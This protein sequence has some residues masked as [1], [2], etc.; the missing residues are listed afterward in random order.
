MDDD[1]RRD[2]MD[3]VPGDNIE[4]WKQMKGRM[5]VQIRTRRI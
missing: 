1:I 3:E 5:E 2:F 4:A